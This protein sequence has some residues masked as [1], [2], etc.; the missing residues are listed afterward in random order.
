MTDYWNHN[1]AYHPELLAA[2]PRPNGRVLDVGC[3]DGLLLKKLSTIAEHVTGI[4]PDESAVTTARARL[5]KT[6]NARIILGDVLESSEL[7]GQQFGLITCVATLHHM[8][9]A[10]ALERMRELLAPGGELRVVGLSTNKTAGDWILSGLLLLPIRLMS[11]LRKE[12][13]YPGMTTAQ[14]HESLS[15]IRRTATAVLPASRVRRRFYYRYT[16]AW[17]KP[18]ST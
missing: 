12:S 17:S 5:A 1:T 15:E 4:D 3:G 10:P 8:P 2:V 18:T 13:G 6:S 14:P 11:K 16:L 9:L 7:D